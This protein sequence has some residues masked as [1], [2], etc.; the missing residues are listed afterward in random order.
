MSALL[1][2]LLEM[3]QFVSDTDA[4]VFEAELWSRYGKEQ[5]LEAI[6]SGLLEHRRLKFRDGY[7]RCVCWL[8]N[9]GRA[10]AGNEEKI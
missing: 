7:G 4:Y 9:K 8:S 2:D 5:T 3:E 1:H 6:Q 10:H